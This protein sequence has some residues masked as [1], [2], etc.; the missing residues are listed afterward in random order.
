MITYLYVKRHRVTGLK[1]FGKTSK[2]DP[3]LYL[4][5]GKH[6]LRH[7][8]KHGKEFVETLQIWK[9]SDLNECS[10]F[11]LKFSSDNQIV[12]SKEWANLKP[13]NGLDGGTSKTGLALNADHKRKISESLKGRVVSEET[14]Q[15]LSEAM[16][17]R[18]RSDD[19]C[20]AISKAATGRKRKTPVSDTTRKKISD[21]RRGTK[22][23]PETIRKL[24]ESKRAEK[25]PFYNK[26]HS[27]DTRLKMSEAA[28]A[29]AKGRF[30]IVD[31][32]GQRRFCWDLNDPRLTSGEFI[33][34]TK[35]PN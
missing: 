2:Q 25:N 27:K 33:K 13:E 11:A 32:S 35:W 19:H 20:L 14:R 31:Q 8:K 24:S 12:E 9:F 16:T 17:G 28:K 3:L 7:I 22:H 1:Y 10:T 34:G 26:Q 5:S 18:T 23:S 4:G 21:H 6:W 29:R 15:K 30:Y